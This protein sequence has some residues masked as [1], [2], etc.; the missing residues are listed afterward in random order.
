MSSGEEKAWNI[1]RGLEPEEV[2]RNAL[3]AYEGGAYRLRSLGMDFSISTAEE[4]ITGLT[5]EARAVAGRLGYFFNHAALWYLA[6]A[7]DIGLTGRLVRP[8]DLKG[9]HHFFQGTHEL[10][11][12]RVAEKYASDREGF[13]A[14]AAALGGK[15]L[16]YGDASAELVPF[17]RV[18]VTLILWLGDE[19]FEPRASMLLDSSAEMQMAL[20][21]IW[22]TAM[23]CTLLML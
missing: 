14:R 1:L 3:V 2:C 15:P 21:I 20:D 8:T 18:P 4:A 9:G 11:L 19:E 16:G 10:P 22:P 23:L 5:P 17:P 6:S 12:G 13:L 7:K